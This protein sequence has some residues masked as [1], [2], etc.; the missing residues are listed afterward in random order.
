[1][2]A[3]VLIYN[4]R[5]GR[6]LRRPGVVQH[7]EAALRPAF[8]D[9]RPVPTEGPDTAGGIATREIAAGATTVFVCGGDGTINEVAQALEGTEVPL[10]ALPGGTACVLANELGLGND[11]G[12]A[13]E[14]LASAEPRA[15]AAG[16][17]RRPDGS[18]RLFLLMA[19][20]GFD[21]RIVHGLD[22][23]LKDRFGKLAYWA[24]ALGQLGAK[25]EEIDVTVDG[26]THRCTFA[27]VSRA[28]NYGGDVDLAKGASLLSESFELLLF[29]GRSVFRF[30]F[31]FAAIVAGLAKRTPGLAVMTTSRVEIAPAS[32][33]SPAHV[34]IDGEYAGTIPASFEIVPSAVRLLV[35]R[36][37]RG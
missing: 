9:V 19:G 8:G 22:L 10:G 6:V 27:L 12:R 30:P 34:Q 25:L 29:E 21:A 28:R 3:S 36:T 32:G 15:I 16:R 7:I 26:S 2:S 4:P 13:A 31:Y 23:K 24:G 37:F 1:M 35:P 33:E 20:I 18:S 11:P 17:L 5:A 14:L